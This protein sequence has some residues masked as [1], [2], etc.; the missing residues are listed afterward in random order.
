[1]S[2]QPVM[3]V[4]R[5]SVVVAFAALVVAIAALA[6]AVLALTGSDSDSDTAGTGAASSADAETATAQA[7]EAAASAGAFAA[8]AE[9][10]AASVDAAAARAAAA[11]V[12]LDSGVGDGGPDV[13]AEVEALLAQAQAAAAAAQAA[14]DGAGAVDQATASETLPEAVDPA[15][16]DSEQAAEAADAAEGATEV[17]TP[18]E[19]VPLPGEPYEF[20]PSADT[21]L[22]VV[23]VAYNSSLNVRDIPN[24]EVIARLANVIDGARSPV[25]EVRRAGS[26]ELAATLDL[27]HGVIATGN[28]RQLPTT[29]WH[30]LRAGDLVGWASA[31][32]LAPLGASRDVTSQVVDVLAGTPTAATL[33]E[34]GLM[35]A[36]VFVSG[37][38]VQPSVTFAGGP[39]VF[40]ALGQI[41]VDVLGLPDDSVHGYRVD[42][43][44]DAAQANGTG[45][46]PFTLRSVTS[47]SICDS[48]RGVSDDDLCN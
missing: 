38:E 35:V 18:A 41:T 22:G 33:E 34:L 48:H 27:E 25:V 2:N 42:I 47:T 37:G 5:R 11:L 39:G 23:G 43:E 1:M 36:G 9:E 28:T 45:T 6:L 7:E 15:E 16:D 3:A 13:V 32:Y 8:M 17:D 44:A 19:T 10:A 30:E 26:N 21:G 29:I 14:A 24:G 20:G 46:G 4:A 31:A 12:T 40:E